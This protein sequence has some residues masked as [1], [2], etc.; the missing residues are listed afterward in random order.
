MFL[1]CMCGSTTGEVGLLGLYINEHNASF[2]NQ[3]LETLTEYC[4]GPCHENQNCIA[5]HESNGLDII[6]ALLLTDIN[7]LGQWRMD[8]VLELKNNASKL[9]L[10]VME[11][12]GDS[13]NAEIILRRLDMNPRRLVDVA[14]RAFHQKA[15][16]IRHNPFGS[17]GSFQSSS[18]DADG[19]VAEDDDDF[20]HGNDAHPTADED[21]NDDENDDAFLALSGGSGRIN[22]VGSTLA[23]ASGG[24]GG[25]GDQLASPREVGHNIY[26]L[27]HQLA[28]HNKELAALIKPST[29]V[30]GGSG[31][32][33][34]EGGGGV[35]GGGSSSSSNNSSG[36]GGV[37]G[38]P[39]GGSGDTLTNTAL[40]Y[41]ANHTA[42]IEVSLPLCCLYFYLFN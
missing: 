12:R 6:T 31:G 11:S 33:T 9:L 21:G 18:A 4:Q 19:S 25:G 23:A 39:G 38:S 42:Q 13:E 20:D 37:G 3:T 5:T 36:G 34:V 26:I 2:I 16:I 41:Y 15:H 22:Q 40:Q 29:S 1:D 30:M 32:T 14:C 17:G 24:G 35:N 28:K 8:L 7:P 10:A 27:C